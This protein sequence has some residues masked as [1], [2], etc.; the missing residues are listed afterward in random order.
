MVLLSVLL[1]RMLTRK[2]GALLTAIRQ[3]REGSYEHLHPYPRHDEIAQIGE[4]FNSLTDRLQTTENLRRRFVS[5][6]SHEL[7]TRWRPF[8]F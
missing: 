8:G 1:S 6:A 4:E 7:K 3:V 5:D 2:I